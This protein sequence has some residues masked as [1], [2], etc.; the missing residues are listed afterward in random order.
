MWQF[1]ALAQFTAGSAAPDKAAIDCEPCS[2]EAHPSC[3]LYVLQRIRHNAHIRQTT[4]HLSV[5]ELASEQE[6]R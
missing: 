6:E 5:N 2:E 4:L 1:K 3:T